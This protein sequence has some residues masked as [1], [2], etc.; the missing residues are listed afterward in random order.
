MRICIFGAGAIGGMIGSL[1]KKSGADVVLIARGDH[2][3]II[4]E[5]GLI[6][7]SQEYDLDICQHCC[8]GRDAPLELP[9]RYTQ[10]KQQ[11]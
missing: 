11:R 2:F 10:Q 6:F 4:K 8:T 1:L 3:K 7:Q 9:N 5:K